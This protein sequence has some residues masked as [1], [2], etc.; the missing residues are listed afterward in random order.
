MAGE[1]AYRIEV[2]DRDLVVRVSRDALDQE[3]V[4][5]FL[6]YLEL[7]SI[8]RRSHLSESD[9]EALS[10]EVDAGLWERL[11]GNVPERT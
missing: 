11:R 7:E 5:R 2:D 4:S 9:V 8:R 3:Q 6:D 1:P 10:S